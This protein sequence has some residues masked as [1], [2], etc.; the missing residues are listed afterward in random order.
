[1]LVLRSVLAK[2]KAVIASCIAYEVDNDI[3]IHPAM[4]S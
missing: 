1:M 2:P 3:S 4:L